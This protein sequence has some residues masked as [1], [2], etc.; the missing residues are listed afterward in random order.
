MKFNMFNW[1]LETFSTFLVFISL[2]RYFTLLY[3]VTI[4]CGTPIVY[5]MG[6]EENR[7]LAK[8]YFKLNIRIFQK[9][10]IEP[11]HEK[12]TVITNTSIVISS[13]TY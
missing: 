9:K 5:F 8:D 10:S 2:N 6:I 1:I 13:E 3:I 11:K 12:K 4:S 7:N